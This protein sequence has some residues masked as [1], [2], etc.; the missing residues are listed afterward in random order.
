MYCPQ[1]IDIENK[2][3]ASKWQSWELGQAFGVQALT[4]WYLDCLPGVPS[5]ACWLTGCESSQW[6]GKSSRVPAAGGGKENQVDRFEHVEFEFKYIMK[7]KFIWQSCSAFLISLGG[8]LLRYYLLKEVYPDYSVYN[9]FCPVCLLLCPQLLSSLFSL[10]TRLITSNVLH[11][12]FIYLVY[13]HCL[14]LLWECKWLQG[15]KFCFVHWCSTR[16][17]CWTL[18]TIHWMNKN[19]F[20]Q[21]CL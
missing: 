1:L 11:I 19:Y 14:S 18:T 2:G 7:T 15:R 21:D 13:Y 9:I 12:L 17:T 8:S 5:R 20:Q 4:W 10:P 6:D 3:I 16:T